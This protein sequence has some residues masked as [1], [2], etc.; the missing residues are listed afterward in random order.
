MISR[1]AS[2]PTPTCWRRGNPRRPRSVTVRR[3][4]GVDGSDRV[5]AHVRR[6]RDQEHR[7]RV[8]VLPNDH[9][10]LAAPDTFYFGNAVGETGDDPANAAVNLF[11]L[12]AVRAHLFATAQ[13]PTN[14]FDL[15][16]DGRVN[17]MDRDC[18]AGAYRFGPA[19]DFAA[20]DLNRRGR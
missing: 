8:T 14:P 17:S 15:D 9:T 1:S 3:G 10:G 6:R 12:G 20:G 13:P 7:L 5:T 11:D 16:R 18:A 19:I 2:A 4:T